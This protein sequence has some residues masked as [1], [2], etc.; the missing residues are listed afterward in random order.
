MMGSE[1]TRWGK[2]ILFLLT[3]IGADAI[4]LA[5]LLTVALPFRTILKL[6]S[7]RYAKNRFNSILITGAST[8]IGAQL[9]KVRPSFLYENP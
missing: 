2:D 4:S 5:Y 6:T 7:T 3:R 8:G 9:A 1:L